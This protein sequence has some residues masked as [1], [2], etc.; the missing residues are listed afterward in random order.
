[1]R[2]TLPAGTRVRF[3]DQSCWPER[4]G[5]TG[6]VV[7]GPGR[8]PWHGVG[9]NEVVILLDDDPLH[10]PQDS[11]AWSCVAGLRMLEVLP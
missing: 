5:C 1:M 4:V 2:M 7:D 8:Y 6:T 3:T 9:K 11:P 10:P